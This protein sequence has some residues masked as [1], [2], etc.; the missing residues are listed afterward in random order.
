M[1]IIS[2]YLGPVES[3]V[4]IFPFVALALTFPYILYEYRHYGAIPLIR[5]ILVYLF[6]L[7][8]INA[9]FQ[10]IL[11]LPARAEVAESAA[12]G[13]Q[14][15]PGHFIRVIRDTHYIRQLTNW[16]AIKEFLKDPVVYQAIL[17]A[18]LLFPLG[19]FLH[20]YYRRGFI[21]SVL[22]CILVSL[23]F[24]VTQLTGLYGFYA[25]AY[26]TFDVDDIILNTAGGAAGWILSPLICL[27]L[28]SREKIDGTAYERGRQIPLFRRFL[29]FFLDFLLISSLQLG[30]SLIIPESEVSYILQVF[31]SVVCTIVYLTLVP[32]ITGGYTIGKWLL[33]LRLYTRK[34][35]KRIRPGFLQ[36]FV[37]ASYISILLVHLPHYW[38]LCQV[39]K[40]VTTGHTFNF[41]KNFQ[42]ASQFIMAFF[43]IEVLARLLM[44]KKEFFFEKISRVWNEN[45]ITG[46]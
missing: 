45:L 32:M 34:R 41:W 17:N 7:Y 36:Y 16:P 5:T 23:F 24:E 2:Q 29:A 12:K 46:P 26:R 43:F 25:H 14:L 30:L 11:P 31:L 20:Y 38:V 3:A 15:D 35:G 27:F 18:V 37:R 10:V 44:D 4:L 39:M 9:Y 13:M 21:L 1:S 33:R 40:Q 8:L 6:I 42:L 28:P 19:V 22:I